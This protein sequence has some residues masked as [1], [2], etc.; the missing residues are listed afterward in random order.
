MSPGVTPTLLERL[1][2]ARVD[3][4][5]AD[6]REVMDEC[7]DVWANKQRTVGDE[8][9]TPAAVP[10]KKKEPMVPFKVALTAFRKKPL[11]H[12]TSAAAPKLII[13]SGPPKLE[14]VK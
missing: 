14:V 6:A 7:R 9:Q 4:S 13:L 10:S 11:T 5:K 3:L 2:Q 8:A 12:V 1:V